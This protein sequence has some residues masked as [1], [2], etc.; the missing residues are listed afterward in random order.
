LPLK[1]SHPDRIIVGERVLF[2]RDGMACTYRVGTSL[3]V[4]FTE[5]DGR[6]HA[7]RITRSRG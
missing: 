3:E 2:L 7:E 5:Q 1:A 4:V 6:S